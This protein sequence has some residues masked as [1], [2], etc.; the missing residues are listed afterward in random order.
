MHIPRSTPAFS[1]LAAL[2]LAACGGGALLVLGFIGSA[3]GSWTQDGDPNQPGLQVLDTCGQFGG[4]RCEVSV[5]PVGNGGAP[6]FSSAYDITYS[7][8]TLRDC[9]ASGQ[10]RVDGRRMVLDGCF[11]GEFVTLN[12]VLSDNGRVRMFVDATPFLQGGVWVELQNGQQRFAFKNN[13]DGCKLGAPPLRVTVILRL[14]DIFNG[15]PYE[16]TIQTFAIGNDAPYSGKFVGIS[17]MRLTRGN[18]VLELERR[19]GNETCP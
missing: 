17:A 15:G 5:Q 13:T 18:E 7:S 8:A 19:P 1:A 16:T 9:P 14:S 11:S 4:E 3:G 6:L 10:G 2:A 12:E